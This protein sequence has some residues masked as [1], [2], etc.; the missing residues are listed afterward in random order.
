MN[1][2]I[3]TSWDSDYRNGKYASDGPIPFVDTIIE[4]VTNGPE[5]LHGL[6]I[7][8]GNGRNYIPLVK[9]GL[10]L[11]GLDISS[12]GLNQLEEQLPANPNKLIH[13]DFLSYN[14]DEQFDYVVS[15]QIFQ[16]GDKKKVEQY[17]SKVDTLLKPGGLF[18]LRVNSVNTD[19]FFKHQVKEKTP[20]GGMTIT[21]EDGPKKGLDVH[22]FSSQEIDSLVF[23]GFKRLKPIEEVFMNRS[24]EK[25]GKWAQFEGVWQKAEQDN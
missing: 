3:E 9:A 11:D 7:G 14:P 23:G 10:Q 6:Y 12:V 24:P 15:I 13:E 21:Y 25:K 20:D 2:F 8:C 17:F 19:I 22:F 18:F 1:E 16:H 5:S 4:H